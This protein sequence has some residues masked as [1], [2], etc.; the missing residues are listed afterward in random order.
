MWCGVVSWHGETELRFTE[1]DTRGQGH[2][3]RN[4]RKKKTVN[5]MVYRDEM[6]THMFQDIY[7]VMSDHIW[8][9]QQDGVEIRTARDTVTWVRINTPDFFS[10]WWVI[11]FGVYCY[12]RFKHT[13]Q[14]SHMLMA[15]NL[16][17]QMSETALHFK[18]SRMPP[19]IDSNVYDGKH[20]KHLH[21]LWRFERWC[22]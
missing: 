4:R 17:W 3:P 22:Y 7:T 1:G 21:W 11:A 6:C 15:W 14:T 13:G 12:R 16:Y 19:D 8:T 20:F 5:H 9:W 2:L 18:L 10:T